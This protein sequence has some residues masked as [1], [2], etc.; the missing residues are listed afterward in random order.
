MNLLKENPSMTENPY[1][2]KYEVGHSS[3][4]GSKAVCLAGHFSNIPMTMLCGLPRELKVSCVLP[5][6]EK[7]RS[8]GSLQVSLPPSFHL[9]DTAEM[10]PGFEANWIWANQWM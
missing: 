5:L 10:S 9:Q 4:L 2:P 3:L 6:L 7:G 8:R 1:H